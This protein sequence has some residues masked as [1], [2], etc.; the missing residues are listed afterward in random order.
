MRQLFGIKTCDTCRRARKWLDDAGIDYAWIDVREDGVSRERLDAWRE[1]LG[2]AA[3][4][5]KRSK[6]WRDFDADQRAAAEADPMPV[7]LAHPTLIKRPIL[8]T[9]RETLAGFS[10]A[11]Y[12]NALTGGSC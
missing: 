12:E 11:R 7:L 5:N 2:D 1:A 3:L 10:R 6:T 4:L 9:P 8:E